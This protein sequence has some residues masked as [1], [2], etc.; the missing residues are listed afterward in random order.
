[1]RVAPVLRNPWK[2]ALGEGGHKQC[3]LLAMFFVGGHCFFRNVGP[4]TSP[5]REDRDSGTHYLCT[6]MYICCLISELSPTCL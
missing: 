5:P 6:I 4:R 2:V 1:M 3:I